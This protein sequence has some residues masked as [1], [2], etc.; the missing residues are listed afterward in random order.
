MLLLYVVVTY[1]NNVI[2]SVYK[3]FTVLHWVKC[4]FNGMNT[5]MSLKKKKT[6]KKKC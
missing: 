6:K 1:I 5:E 3:K 2:Q 4:F